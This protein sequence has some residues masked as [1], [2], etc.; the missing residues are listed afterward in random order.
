MIR[1]FTN[2]GIAANFLMFG[3]LLAGLYTAFF[4]IPLE[5]S[6]AL[7]WNLVMMDMRYRGATPKDIEKA[8]LIPVEAAL[9][10]VQG[11]EQLNADGSS[12]RARFYL[13]AKDGVDL[14]A[15]MD[16]VKAAVDTINTFPQETEPPRIFIPE[17]ANSREVL[18][19]AVA[20]NLS[21]HDLLK[22]ARQVSDDL[23]EIPGISRTRIQGD[24]DREISVEADE[25]RLRSY[26]L[27]F[28]Q[29]A[30]AIRR[31]SVDMPAGSIDSES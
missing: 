15:L 4:K 16:D 9:E 18:T 14:R 19:I 21:D 11:I 29:I 1:W 12:G 25:E 5:V 10:G 26:N 6:P 23:L 24:R 31:N 3:I 20:G 2:N 22:A 7:S 8:I 28:Q 17:S 27:T 13:R 30:D